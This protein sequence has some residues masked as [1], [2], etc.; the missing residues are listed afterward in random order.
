MLTLHT[1]DLGDK[2]ILHCSGRIVHGNETRILCAALHR[3][4]REI[5]LELSNVH[6]IDA[7][8]L[9]ALISLQAAGIYV[10]LLNPSH[11][12][13]ELLKIS[14]LDSIFE[15]I[16][17]EEPLRSQTMAQ[18]SVSSAATAAP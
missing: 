1:E 17:S 9:G 11:T 15:I 14:K 2:V 5:L 18:F 6:S 8:G 3:H 4:K 7:A 10:R 16:E 13:R 12:V